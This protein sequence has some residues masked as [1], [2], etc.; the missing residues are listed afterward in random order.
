VTLQPTPEQ[1]AFCEIW[2]HVMAISER[3]CVVPLNK[4]QGLWE[5]RRWVKRWFL[6]YA[7]VR[8]HAS[9]VERRTIT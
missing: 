8:V 4:H 3:D 6:G 7:A 2:H 5:R 9:P 1:Q